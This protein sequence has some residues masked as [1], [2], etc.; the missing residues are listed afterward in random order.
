MKRKLLGKRRKRGGL[1]RTSLVKDD[2]IDIITFRYA[3]QR[4]AGGILTVSIVMIS[5]I[6]R[7]QIRDEHTSCSHLY[8]EILKRKREEVTLT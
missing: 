3:L 1:L 4:S 8:F 7:I 2:I 5:V 6:F